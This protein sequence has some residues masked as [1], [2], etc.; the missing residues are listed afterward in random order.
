VASVFDEFGCGYVRGDK[1]FLQR[2]RRDRSIE[3]LVGMGLRGA[4][5][6]AIARAPQ[7][8]A[9]NKRA[10]RQEGVV[11]GISCVVLLPGRLREIELHYLL[12]REREYCLEEAGWI[13]TL[14]SQVLVAIAEE[15]IGGDEGE[16]VL[17]LL[18]GGSNSAE[19]IRLS[20]CLTLIRNLLQIP[21]PRPG[22]LGY[23][24]GMETLQLHFVRLL[25]DEEATT[26]LQ[27]FAENIG[28]ED[29][30]VSTQKR[31]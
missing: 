13:S 29:D 10:V 5:R 9:A 3:L 19:S 18:F 11:Y 6:E 15:C 31:G 17:G 14:V 8:D 7:S 2:C 20:Q 23:R 27:M 24:E 22:D 12:A 1:S 16:G 21:D 25:V 26:L 28:G 30:P 4:R